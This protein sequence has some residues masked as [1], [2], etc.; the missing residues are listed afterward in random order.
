[1]PRKLPTIRPEGADYEIRV[2]GERRQPLWD[3]YHLLL[4]LTWLQ[5]ISGIVLVFLAVN[6]LFAFAY[7]ESGG[8]AHAA[9]GSFADAF[10][11]SVQ[12]LGT[13]GYGA[14]YPESR[15]ANVLVVVQTI[16]G[17]VLTALMTGLLFAK[18]SRPTA[19][20]R[21]TTNAVI[22]PMHGK[23]TLM[24]RVG[25]ERGHNSIVDASIRVVLSRT[26]HPAEGGIFY[27]QIDLKL[28]RDRT[29]SLARSWTVLHVI[30]ETSPLFGYAIDRCREEEIELSVLVV[31]LD[32]TTMQTIHA[33]HHFYTH[34]IVWDAR[35]KDILNETADG[36]MELD[37]RDFDTTVASEPS[38]YGSPRVR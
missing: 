27:R 34:Q 36:A 21:F 33:I 25:N 38:L 20:V 26:E 6:T 18:F 35:F 29:L 14:M 28:A 9:A 24:F 10:F 5:T 23:P 37:L 4:R 1:V 32:D 15:A 30:D 19:R 22:G 13:I 16:T 2:V 3:F 31:G 8:V 17:F 11:F 12:T 7:V